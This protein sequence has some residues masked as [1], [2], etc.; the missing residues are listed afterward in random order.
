LLRLRDIYCFYQIRKKEK[1]ILTENL[2]R[3]RETQFSYFRGK[4]KREKE[5]GNDI[6]KR[7]IQ[8]M[9]DRK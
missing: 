9:D 3:C 8:E 1:K 7:I 5:K 2:Q 4:I 6:R